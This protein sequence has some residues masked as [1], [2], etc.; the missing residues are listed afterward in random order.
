MK[1]SSL[2]IITTCHKCNSEK[3]ISYFYFVYYN[4]ISRIK[5]LS[6]LCHKAPFSRA[7]EIVACFG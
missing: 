6:N 5:K 3:S 7:A 1:S 4:F 2:D